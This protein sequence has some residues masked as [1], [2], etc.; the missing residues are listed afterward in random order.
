MNLEDLEASRELLDYK[1]NNAKFLEA[2]NRAKGGDCTVRISN[3]EV[4]IE[5]DEI[6]EFKDSL[7]ALLQER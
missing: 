5:S 2:L 6:A 3:D 7:A 4:T 1:I